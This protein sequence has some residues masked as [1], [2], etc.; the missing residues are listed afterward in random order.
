MSEWT[1]SRMG[2]HTPERST[3]FSPSQGPFP[4]RDPLGATFW[5]ENDRMNLVSNKHCV[6]DEAGALMVA[7]VWGG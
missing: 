2:S 4:E 7:G 1:E 3:R 5:Y 6:L